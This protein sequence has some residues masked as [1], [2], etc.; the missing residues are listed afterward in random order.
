MPITTALAMASAF[1]EALQSS[2]AV[3][4]VFAVPEIIAEPEPEPAPEP[5]PAPVLVL[6]LE[7]DCMA[8]MCVYH[9]LFTMG[10]MAAAAIALK[11]LGHRRVQ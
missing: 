8:P 3:I 4:N 2:R 9:G 5:A 6:E 11:V 7:P 1:P 10:C